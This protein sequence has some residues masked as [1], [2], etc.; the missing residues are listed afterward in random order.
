MRTVNMSRSPIYSEGY[1]LRAGHAPLSFYP[2]RSGQGIRR[3]LLALPGRCWR[4]ICCKMILLT[5]FAMTT[6]IFGG[7]TW[8]ILELDGGE[9]PAEDEAIELIL[10]EAKIC[11]KNP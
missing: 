6:G 2:H 11:N 8:A 5:I 3:F 9:Y 7:A 4:A 10:R 1:V